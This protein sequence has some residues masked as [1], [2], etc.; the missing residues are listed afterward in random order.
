[1][2]HFRSFEEV[3]GISKKNVRLFYVGV[4]RAKQQLFMSYAFRRALYSGGGTLSRPSEFLADLPR[5]LLDGSPL[6]LANLNK[7]RSLESQTRW[8][9]SASSVSRLEHDLKSNTVT[10]SD[11]K[12]R[13]KIIP[14]PGSQPAGGNEARFKIGQRVSH[15]DFGIGEVF[16]VE[17][18]GAII[19]V[20]FDDHGL[21][22]ILSDAEGFKVTGE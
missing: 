17:G 3:D 14:F 19:N 20:I 8:D 2:P 5:H 15:P 1:M 7:A 22:K 4:T 12:I 9:N 18:D 21:K 6:T 13:S 11:S 10:P 16:G